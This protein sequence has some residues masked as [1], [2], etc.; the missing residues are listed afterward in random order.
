MRNKFTKQNSV[1]HSSFKFLFSQYP[2]KCS[3][4]KSVKSV[5]FFHISFA[6]LC[7]SFVIQLEAFVTVCIPS[8]VS[9]TPWFMW[10]YFI[11][12]LQSSLFVLHSCMGFE[13]CIESCIYQQQFHLPPNSLVLPLCHQPLFPPQTLA[14]TDE[15]SVPLVS[16]FQNFI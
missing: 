4:P 16:P 13:K 10:F 5:L 6:L 7:H 3:F 2:A 12:I 9:L 15:F 1:W 11:C 14:T 8:L